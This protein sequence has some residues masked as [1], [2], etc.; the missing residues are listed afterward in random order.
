[1]KK[2]NTIR[3]NTGR[4]A[5]QTQWLEY[6]QLLMHTVLSIVALTE[7]SANYERV[8][9]WNDTTRERTCHIRKMKKKLGQVEIH[10]WPFILL[11]EI[12]LL[13]YNIYCYHLILKEK[14]FDKIKMDI[15]YRNMPERTFISFHWKLSNF[16]LVF[17]D[18]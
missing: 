5:S 11:T 7:C 9:Y 16:Y 17:E 18:H 6:F 14:L 8:R 4:D 15:M 12:R 3:I 13:M 2:K 10:E 1:M